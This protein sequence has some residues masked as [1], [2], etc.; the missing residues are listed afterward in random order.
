MR[1]SMMVRTAALALVAGGIAACSDSTSAPARAK[2]AAGVSSLDGTVTG[3]GHGHANTDST[4]YS[5]QYTMDP[6]QPNT[7]KF[8]DHTVTFPAGSI[9]DPATSGYDPTLWDAPCTPLVTPLVISAT[10][11]QKA[12]HS[13]IDF[14]PA[15][16]F[17]PTSVQSQWVTL[18][19]K[20]K[21][22]V[23]VTN[24]YVIAWNRPSDGA[25]IDESYTDSSLSAIADQANNRVSRRVKHFSGYVVSATSSTCDPTLDSTCLLIT[26]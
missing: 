20:E 9:C 21:D 13:Y 18:S 16:R 25:W 11:T 5:G 17:V 2:F 24:N 10:W 6:T 23:L 14:Q 26:Y 19:L 1:V 22:T 4:V 15:L 12:G 7:L 8:G 3:N